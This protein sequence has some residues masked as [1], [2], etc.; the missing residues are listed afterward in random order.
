MADPVYLPDVNILVAAHPDTSPFHQL[1]RFWLHQA[2]HFATTPITETGMLR[3][4]MAPLPMPRRRVTTPSWHC[5]GF[6]DVRRTS[7]GPTTFRCRH[8]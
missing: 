6:G 8:R 3:V 7:S 1:A 5:I 4:L 2:S